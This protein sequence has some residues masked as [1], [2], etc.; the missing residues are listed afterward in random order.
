MMGDILF[1]AHRIPFPPDRGDKIRAHH[2]LKRLAGLAP[3]HVGCFVENDADRA[4]IPTLS[5]LAD[6]CH[7]ADR[8]KSIAWAGI[9]A[10]AAGKPVSLTAFHHRGLA[11]WVQS[12]IEEC[13]IST[14]F[15]FSGQMGQ[16]IPHEFAGRVIVDLC[17]VDSVKF[18]DYAAAGERVW[19][20]RREGRLLALEEERLV[21]RADTT[22]LIS[23]NEK[24]V[25]Q[26]RLRNAAG[27]RILAM[28]NGIDAGFFDPA[29][30]SAEAE[31]TGKPGPHFIFTGQMDYRPN[32]LAALWVVDEFMPRMREVRPEAQFHV[33]GRNP[34]EKLKA[35]NGRQGT[36][37]WGEVPDVRPFLAAADVALA[38]LTIA[39]G[40]QNKVL[41]AMAMQLPVLLTPGAATG[42]HATDGRHW[43]VEEPDGGA[44][45]R[46]FEEL[47]A[48]RDG[49]DAMRA[50]AR[51]FVLQNHS[52][53]AIL[54]P[55][56][57]LVS[58]GEVRRR[59]A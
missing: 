7:V 19:L 26:G 22:L 54:E 44:M 9:E 48:K 13:D 27:A 32:E 16:Y 47:W 38:P 41:E 20:N 2:L 14:I 57:E 58:A 23:E 37:I 45:V 36:R 4:A 53:Q 40:I 39:R 17:D 31:I 11:D 33:V 12:T 24:R 30:V 28:G 6:S 10:L 49:R 5:R 52:W 18:E 43:M 8:S 1:L 15:V 51:Q 50:A 55:L 3:V 46:R 21:H 34:T 29:M 35:R 56:E 42:I 25:L 59:A